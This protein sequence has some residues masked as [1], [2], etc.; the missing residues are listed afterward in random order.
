[1]EENSKP[2]KHEIFIWTGTK[3]SVCAWAFNN[4]KDAWEF[5]KSLLDKELILD[6]Y[7][8]IGYS[9]EYG[10]V[11]YLTDNNQPPL[12]KERQVINAN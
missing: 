2:R 4:K 7:Y 11:L 10:R 9:D 12:I 6:K 5:G 1:M 3:E 8:N